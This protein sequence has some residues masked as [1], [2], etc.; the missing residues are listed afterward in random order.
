M[1]TD[2]NNHFDTVEALRARIFHLET[3]LTPEQMVVA[4]LKSEKPAAEY[5]QREAGWKSWIPGMFKSNK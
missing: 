5:I 1:L 3:K 2:L 4:F